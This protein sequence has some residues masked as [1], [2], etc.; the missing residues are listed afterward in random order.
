MVKGWIA[1]TAERIMK[2]ATVP[3]DAVV[4]T[5]TETAVY[6]A[7]TACGLGADHYDPTFD[8]GKAGKLNDVIV[9][10]AQRLNVPPPI[11][12]VAD[13]IDLFDLQREGT[14]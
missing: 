7:F 5:P 8:L 9:L 11:A 10:A 4:M 1:S 12:T 14:L 3:T 2:W 13:V 6:A